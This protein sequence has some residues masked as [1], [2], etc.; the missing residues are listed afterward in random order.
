[1]LRVVER[2]FG[3]GELTGASAGGVRTGYQL[4]VYR[5]WEDRSGTLT[6]GDFVVEGHVLAPPDVLRPLLLTP[7]PLLLT[8][9]DG[10]RVRVYVVSEDGA[11]SG[12]D[13]SGLEEKDA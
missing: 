13:G 7:E 6:A 10:R 4:A 11:V 3:E 8:L 9:E 12:A 1:V 5:N 2:L